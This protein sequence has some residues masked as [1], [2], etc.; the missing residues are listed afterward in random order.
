MRLYPPISDPPCL[1]PAERLERLRRSLDGLA[2]DLRQGN[3]RAVAQA[4]SGAVE[5]AL[6]AFLGETGPRSRWPYDTREPLPRT[7]RSPLRWDE[8]P[9][10]E[11]VDPWRS[12]ASYASPV[13]QPEEKPHAGHWVPAVAAGVHS[14]AWWLR[15]SRHQ[16]PI[17]T[18]LGV[19][20]AAGIAV[21]TAGATGVLG[22]MGSTLGLLALA[23]T[24]RFAPDAMTRAVKP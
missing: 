8:D 22:L 24:A 9:E 1:S 15:R 12:G 11:D 16:R 23:D 5:Q 10:K 20:L 14:A 13:R 21:L 17:L 7:A 19:G 6:T 2:A 18:T 4:V 3:A